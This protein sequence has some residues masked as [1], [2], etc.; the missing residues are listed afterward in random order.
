[1]IFLLQIDFILHIY[2]EQKVILKKFEKDL[3]LTKKHL[4]D[5]FYNHYFT[6]ISRAI[7]TLRRRRDSNSR[8]LLH[9]ASLAKRY[10]RPLRHVSK[11]N[12]F[13]FSNILLFSRTSFKEVVRSRVFFC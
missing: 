7:T 12:H 1:M 11:Y 3:I 9:P 2:L 10:V 4:L 13:Y 5:A 8:G 6:H